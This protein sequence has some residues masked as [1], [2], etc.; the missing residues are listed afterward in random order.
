MIS[1][2][3]GQNIPEGTSL[4]LI[5]YRSIQKCT[6]AAFLLFFFLLSTVKLTFNTQSCLFP[7][8]LTRHCTLAWTIIQLRPL[9]HAQPCV[10]NSVMYTLVLFNSSASSFFITA[11]FYCQSN[12]GEV[13]TG[14]WLLHCTPNL[15]CDD[16]H[17]RNSSTVCLERH[18]QGCARIFFQCREDGC[19][20]A[21]IK[22]IVADME[23]VTDDHCV[24][25][26]S[27]NHSY[28]PTT[29]SVNLTVSV[30]ASKAHYGAHLT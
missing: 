13:P 16:R 12:P 5:K 23:H 20:A 30:S 27:L 25:I 28:F 1:P 24:F 17:I 18:W 21:W 9:P 10:F 8:T 15:C 19:D 29:Q 11:L 2:L 26:Y 3:E 7:L 4:C 14:C 6:F 22:A